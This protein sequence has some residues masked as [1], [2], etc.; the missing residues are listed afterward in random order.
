MEIDTET[1]DV[2]VR[3][4]INNQLVVFSEIESVAKVLNTGN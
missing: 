4:L 2:V 1:G 3:F